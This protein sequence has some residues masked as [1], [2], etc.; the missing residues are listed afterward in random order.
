MSRTAIENRE[1]NPLP[2]ASTREAAAK[3]H[4]W[5]GA[6]Q[7]ALLFGVREPRQRSPHTRRRIEDRRETIEFAGD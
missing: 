6:A 3:F 1:E 5:Q 7:S 4:L 2:N